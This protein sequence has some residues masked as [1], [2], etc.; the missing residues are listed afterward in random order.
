MYDGLDFDTEITRARFEDL[1]L[2]LFKNTLIPV[3][4]VLEDAKLTVRDIHDVV[5]VGGSTRI[6]KVQ[7]LLKEFFSGKELCNTVDQD[8]AVAYGAAVEGSI[9]IGSSKEIS[10]DLILLDVVPLS[11][12]VETAG[13]VM[14]KIIPRNSTVSVARCHH[15]QIPTRRT[16]TFSTND[17]FQE[18]VEVQVF[19]GER[20]FTKDNNKLASFILTGL[21]HVLKGIPQIEVTFDIDSNGIL[22]VSAVENSTGKEAA[23][24]VVNDKSGGCWGGVRDRPP[25]AG[26][27]CCD[28][29]GGGEVPGA[30]SGEAGNIE[31]EDESRDVFVQ[32]VKNAEE[33]RREEEYA[34]GD[35]G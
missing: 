2:T 12:G 27:D 13:G 24:T 35:G 7:E 18:E 34:E 8:E 25:E 4:K 30:G 31:G 19:E 21:P 16:Q 17:D 6:P 23:I 5:L 33:E 26:G 15:A 32:G 22:N 20:P 1:N 10:T 29:R 28:D 14:T 11:L 9:L 3:R